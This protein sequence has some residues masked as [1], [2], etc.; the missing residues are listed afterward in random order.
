[1]PLFLVG[2]VAEA[3]LWLLALRHTID[4]WTF[5][6]VTAVI[7]VGLP[8]ASSAINRTRR[9]SHPADEVP[10]E[11]VGIERPFTAEDLRA[12]GRAVGTE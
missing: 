9:A 1:M 10:L 6:I 8:R 12:I 7:I 5:V 3:V 2:V 11:L 4:N